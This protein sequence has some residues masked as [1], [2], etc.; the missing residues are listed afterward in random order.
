MHDIA[1]RERMRRA[2]VGRWSWRRFWLGLVLAVMGLAA[3][4]WIVDL[5]PVRFAARWFAE[6]PL[7][8]WLRYYLGW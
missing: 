3:L 2:P 1:I 5:P 8:D 4:A 6:T 7:C